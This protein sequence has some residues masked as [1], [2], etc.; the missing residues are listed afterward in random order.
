MPPSIVK[1]WAL[2]NNMCH[3]AKKGD[4]IELT[5]TFLE[6]GKS[7]A[8]P[9]ESYK[10]FLDLYDQDIRNGVCLGLVERLGDP[11]RFFLEIDYYSVKPHSVEKLEKMLIESIQ[12][13]G[14][15]F[16]RVNPLKKGGLITH[17]PPE[18]CKKN[19]LDLYK[20]GIHIYF[21]KLIVTKKDAITIC[22]QLANR[23]AEEYEEFD[24]NLWKNVFDISAY[25]N[26]ALRM[27]GSQKFKNCECSKDLRCGECINGRVPIGRVYKIYK[28]FNHLGEELDLEIKTYKKD[29]YRKLSIRADQIKPDVL[30]H[31][32]WFD[33]SIFMKSKKTDY[34]ESGEDIIGMAGT[35]DVNL[36]TD[37]KTAINLLVKRMRKAHPKYFRTA[38]II[39]IKKLGQAYIV[40]TDCKMCLNLSGE[41]RSNHIY[42]VINR[43]GIYQK[44]HC[45]C[46]TIRGSGKMCKDF[47]SPIIDH[48][49]KTL[50]ILFNTHSSISLHANSISD[51]SL[52]LQRIRQT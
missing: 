49:P 51:L 41:H 26:G 7:L 45:I 5:H 14:D 22:E 42:F 27:M 11:F 2:E 1:K 40:A 44:C 30:M 4:G 46:E 52:M 12:Y 3:S 47:E 19:D 18:V 13:V 43:N 10:T 36:S 28:M 32:D 29:P 31:P 35:S 25:K 37:Q 9:P 8:I 17:V 20:T 23:F 50:S 39:S 15:F 48:D 21:P 34:I 16:P 6:K 24:W 33:N 38:R